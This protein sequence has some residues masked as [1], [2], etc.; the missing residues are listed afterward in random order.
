MTPSVSV[1]MATYNGEAY[2]GQQLESLAAQSRLPDEL[3][4]S[5]DNSTDGSV[6]L[7]TT[8]ARSAPF[9][10]RIIRNSHRAGYAG[11]FNRAL[12][13][14]SGTLVF[15]CDQD[16]AWFPT[17]IET[18]VEVSLREPDA[19]V[20]MNDVAMTYKDLS[21]AGVTKLQQYRRTGQPLSTYVMGAAAAVRREFLDA[22]L[23]IP[24]EYSSHDKW[25]V[26]FATLMNRRYLID[27]PLQ[28]YRIH[29]ANTSQIMVNTT[30]RLSRV[31]VLK[32]RL[33]QLRFDFPNDI[34][35]AYLPNLELEIQGARLAQVRSQADLSAAFAKVAGRLEETR[36]LAIVRQELQLLPR[37][38]R[39]P[40]VMR[41]WLNG[42][43]A[44]FKGNKS[45]LIDLFVGPRQ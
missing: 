42:Q 7:L 35:G 12:E 1:A 45:V 16:D 41:L 13:A 36:R 14:T 24:A 5:D 30:A 8:F 40:I 6:E 44:L 27:V 3:V 38:K 25:L 43:Y 39:L 2:L 31:D 34:E 17:K 19:M 23:P 29:G 21:P 10:V 11:N 37:L 28:W 33:E 15:L 4:V 26:K 18:I 9:A 32:R 20:I 22:V